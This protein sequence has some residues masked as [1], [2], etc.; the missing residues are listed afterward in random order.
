MSKQIKF[1][2]II[3]TRDRCA[4]LGAT[5]KTCLA[6]DY[7]NYEIIVSDNCSSDDTK[8]LVLKLNHPNIKYINTN[9]RVSMSQNWDFALQFATGDFITI[10]G[11][12]DGLLF[13][14]LGEI[15]SIIETT[16]TNAVA[17]KQV[18]Y[19]WPN[20]IID[21]QKNLISIPLSKKL[22]ERNA[23]EYLQR[24][25]NFEISY[26]E[27]SFLYKGMIHRSVIEKVRN[28]SG[29][30]FFHSQTPDLYSAIA[31]ASNLD[32]YFYSEKP[33]SINGA[34]GS[35]NGTSQFN[36][37]LSTSEYRKFSS[38]SNIPFHPKLS[39]CPSI[40]MLTAECFYQAS[41][42][43][44]DKKQ[45][46]QIKPIKLIESL[47][48]DA[49]S[50]PRWKFDAIS[51]ALL[52]TIDINQWNGF[53]EVTNAKLNKYK[54][55]IFPNK[56]RYGFLKRENTVCIDGGKFHIKDVY[57]AALLCNFIL[58]HQN[59]SLMINHSKSFMD[60]IQYKVHRLLI[61]LKKLNKLF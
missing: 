2:I 32:T 8:N 35:S 1:S 20:H 60:Q 37:N 41:D 44:L 52:K 36:Q 54:E 19:H 11:D 56:L 18:S 4:T 39:Y 25:L 9:T 16:K 61:K 21:Y 57:D 46:L 27:I 58:N 29:G 49:L 12:D 59:L 7:S 14:A 10:L 47:L 15:E 24:V 3:P 30:I 53:Y 50:S 17:W 55:R 42:R 5:L 6:Q 31:L 40:S 38:E 13:G 34:S 23:S 33:F 22:E 28:L 51:M 26:D 43:L 45:N 48:N